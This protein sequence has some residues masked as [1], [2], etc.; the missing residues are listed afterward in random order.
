MELEWVVVGLA[1]WLISLG[2]RLVCEAAPESI[3]LG[4]SQHESARG[5]TE[6]PQ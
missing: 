5:T 3:D 6:R 4:Y 1:L 2:T